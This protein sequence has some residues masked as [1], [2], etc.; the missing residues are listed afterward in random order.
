MAISA[1]ERYSELATSSKDIWRYEATLNQLKLNL[2]LQ[3]KQLAQ[4]LL[5][6]GV[7]ISSTSG[8]EFERSVKELYPVE[9]N[10]IL[11]LVRE[12]EGTIKLLLDNL[13]VDLNGKVSRAVDRYSA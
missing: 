3:P 13:D 4:T 2:W 10:D 9:C 1:I 7:S 8:A 11:G 6:M 12:V 5:R